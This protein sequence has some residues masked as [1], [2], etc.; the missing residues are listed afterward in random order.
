MSKISFLH[1]IYLNLFAV[2]RLKSVLGHS[3]SCRRV[4]AEDT[5]CCTADFLFSVAFKKEKPPLTGTSCDATCYHC[6]VKTL[7]T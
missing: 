2:T 3:S 7:T 6:L 5:E 1:G 4:T